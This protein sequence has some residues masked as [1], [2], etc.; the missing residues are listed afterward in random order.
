MFSLLFIIQLH[1]IQGPSFIFNNLVIQNL[2]F[3]IFECS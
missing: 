1:N 3:G 2:I